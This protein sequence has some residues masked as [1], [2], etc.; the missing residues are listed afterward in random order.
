MSIDFCSGCGKDA[1]VQTIKINDEF[2]KVCKICAKMVYF[3]ICDN[4]CDSCFENVK[5]EIYID[6]CFGGCKSGLKAYLNVLK[7]KR[8][9]LK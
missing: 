5:V 7:E 3:Y 9:S 8:N 6:N 4:M 2:L 1:V